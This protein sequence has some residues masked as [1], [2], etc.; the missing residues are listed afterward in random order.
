MA[1]PLAFSAKISA[2]MRASRTRSAGCRR[3]DAETGGPSKAILHEMRRTGARRDA[4]PPRTVTVVWRQ[5]TGLI[6]SGGA[7]P[8]RDS[9]RFTL[10]FAA[11]APPRR[12]AATRQP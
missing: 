1:Q 9:A 11:G 6:P 3:W 8:L 2:A 7:S 10:D 4:L 5:A 12:D